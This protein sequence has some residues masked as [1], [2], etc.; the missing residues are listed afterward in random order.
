MSQ[1]P[2][3]I[4]GYR[5][6]ERVAVGGMAE[7]FKAQRPGRAGFEE[8]IAIK[9]MLAHLADDPQ[10]VSMFIDE[11]KLTAQFA[12]KHIVAV[13]ELGA[14]GSR[15]YIAMQYVDGFDVLGLLRNCARTQ[16][17]LPAALAAFIAHDVLDALDYAHRAV[18]KNGRHMQVVHRDVS[19][20]NVLLSW[21]GD[22]FLTDFGIARAVERRH[23]TEAGTVKGKVGYMSPEQLGGAIVD[24]KSDIFSVGVL[25]AEMV[26]ARRL[27]TGPSELEALLAVRDA[28]VSRLHEHADDFP[29]GLLTL[30]KRALQRN[31]QERYAT[32]G[33]FRDALAKWLRDHAPTDRR[34]LGDFVATVAGAPT[35]E[36]YAERPRSDAQDDAG[37]LRSAQGHA[38]EDV[39]AARAQ[40]ASHAKARTTGSSALVASRTTPPR[41]TTE[42]ISTEEI[43]E[44]ISAAYLVA[45][46]ADI[47]E[48]SEV[49][50]VAGARA[51][52]LVAPTASDARTTSKGGTTPPPAAARHHSAWTG[53][54]DANL[55]LEGQPEVHA[56]AEM[57]VIRTLHRIAQKERRGLLSLS[58]GQGALKQVYFAQGQPKFIHSNDTRER[59]GEF[60][61]SNRILTLDDLSN[62]LA[63]IHHFNG[64]LADTLV[65]LGLQTPLAT[66]QLFARY[67]AQKLTSTFAWQQGT[68][69]FVPMYR[70]PWHARPLHLDALRLLGTG[71]AQ[72]D[73]LHIDAWSNQHQRRFVLSAPAPRAQLDDFGLGD[74]L[75]RVHALLDGQ[76]RLAAL[77]ARVRAG[78]ARL[79]L[80]RLVYL[81]VETDYARLQ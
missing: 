68:A 76:T 1:L 80:L 73:P 31:P 22:I 20:G 61:V 12:H 53:I 81:L 14:E 27:F 9:R 25:L 49:H 48:A 41:P 75:V 71:V 60:L 8:L 43:I 79:N 3:S 36:V 50:R 45:D 65:G 78:Q 67:V 4:G 2:Q 55:P 11:A 6:L 21:R 32:A 62:A 77:V 40:F 51:V 5:I 38:A 70:N 47:R 58:N 15:P 63:V 74:A 33:A 57:S 39:Q 26:M 7:L 18:D 16:I 10:F 17:R 37:P 28:N 72:L 29:A 23:K 59:F 54:D 44:E 24:G 46:D 42:A 66:Y 34:A 19:P 69:T 13:Y 64:N 35:A 52:P 30:V 56:L